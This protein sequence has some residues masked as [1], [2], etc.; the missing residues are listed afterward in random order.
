MKHLLNIFILFLFSTTLFAEVKLPEIISTHMVLQCEKQVPIW[1][2]AKPG[3]SVEVIFAGQTKAVV[4]AKDGRWM[5]L[6]DPMEISSESRKFTVKGENTIII[7]DVIVGEVWFC[8][9]QSNMAYGFKG[10]EQKE[11]LPKK[12]DKLIRYFTPTKPHWRDKKKLIPGK[13]VAGGTRFSSVAVNFGARLRTELNRPVGLLSSWKGGGNIELWL[14][15]NGCNMFPGLKKHAEFLKKKKANPL[16]KMSRKLRGV[17]SYYKSTV[18]K[19]IPFAIRGVIWY[20]GEGNG[21]ER[22][23]YQTKMAAL[24]KGWRKTWH[25]RVV[26]YGIKLKEIDPFYFAFVQLANFGKPY[27]KPAGGD[28]WM[29]VREAQLKSLEIPSTGMAVII[30]IGEAGDIHPKNKYDVGNRLA[31]WPLAK[32]YKKELVYS[33]PLYKSQKIEG[34]KIRLI[35]DHIGTGLMVGKKVG[36]KPTLEVKDGKLGHF[37]IAGED[38]KWFWAEAVIDGKDVLVSC[39]DVKKPIAIRYGFAKNPAS[40]NLYNKE[41]LPAS[42]FRTDDWLL[43]KIKRKK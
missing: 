30:D 20:Q 22:K 40:A 34:G 13:W 33:G 35:F 28:S 2:S 9:G 31:L 4:A 36:L 12:G 7:E 43:P 24:I 41:G 14:E 29:G 27:D 37:S 17:A 25:D 8:A 42:P 3:E 39:K 26:S 11:H 1:G 16:E 32:V 6:L 5:L 21:G 19:Q 23:T 10:N 18:T 15:Y 38:K